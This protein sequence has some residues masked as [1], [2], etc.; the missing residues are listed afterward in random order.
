MG[1][2]CSSDV[3]VSYRTLC[4]DLRTVLG[5]HFHDV[6]GHHQ[7]G[8]GGDDADA[9]HEWKVDVQ[10][11]REDGQCDAEKFGYSKK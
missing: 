7:R 8:N 2:L 6:D 1:V 10:S 3:T 11:I 5:H 4:L 9:D